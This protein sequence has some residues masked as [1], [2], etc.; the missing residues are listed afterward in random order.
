MVGGEIKLEI[1]TPFPGFAHS[2]PVG[3]SPGPRVRLRSC[4]CALF[5]YGSC[6]VGFGVWLSSK[7]RQMHLLISV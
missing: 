5:C 7:G 2:I 6:T 1:Q 4:M 3:V